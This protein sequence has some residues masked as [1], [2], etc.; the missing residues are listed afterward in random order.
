M[1][2]NSQ[3]ILWW[4]RITISIYLEK[5]RVTLLRYLAKK[6]SILSRPTKNG[7]LLLSSNDSRD[8]WCTC[9]ILKC[10]F[11]EDPRLPYNGSS[12]SKSYICHSP[13]IIVL[14]F[15]IYNIINLSKYMALIKLPNQL[16]WRPHTSHNP[17]R[18][19]TSMKMLLSFY[20]LHGK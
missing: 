19:L 6:C 5:W 4:S 10:G 7:L 14:G 11:S 17:F 8:L 3:N 20:I 2:Y 15:R 9:T 1:C 12:V 18:S 13:F 16:I